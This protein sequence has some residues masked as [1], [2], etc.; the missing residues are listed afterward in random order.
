MPERID[1]FSGEYRFLSNFSPAF[2]CWMGQW[3]P[4]SEHAYQAAKTVDPSQRE[5]IAR[6][7]TAGEAKKAG[8]KLKLRPDWELVKIEVMASILRVKFSHPSYGHRLKATEPAELIEGN[9]W[10]DEF[11]GVC[12]GKGENHLGKLL[13]QIR[14]ELPPLPKK[15]NFDD[16]EDLI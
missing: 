14:E 13:M 11:W 16:I 12:K 1:T 7:A 5:A 8:Q 4:S 2:F 3:Y 15:P 10:G 9:Y 6:L